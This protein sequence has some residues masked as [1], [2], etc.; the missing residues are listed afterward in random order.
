MGRE[1]ELRGRGSRRGAEREQLRVRE[2]GRV[3]MMGVRS[4][5]ESGEGGGKREVLVNQMGSG[6]FSLVD[7]FAV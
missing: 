6:A 4:G 5:V 7:H 3:E 2:R 1:R